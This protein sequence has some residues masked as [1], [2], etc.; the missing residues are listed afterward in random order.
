MRIEYFVLEG[1][2]QRKEKEEGEEKEDDDGV[3]KEKLKEDYYA[4]ILQKNI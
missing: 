1:D 3:K 2:G 4:D